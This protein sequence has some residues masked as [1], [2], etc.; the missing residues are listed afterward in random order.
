MNLKITSMTQS[1][2]ERSVRRT[3]LQRP[4]SGPSGETVRFKG[5]FPLDFLINIYIY[6]FTIS[7]FFRNPAFKFESYIHG[8]LSEDPHFPRL[9]RI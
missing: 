9:S 5:Y 1:N 4:Q 6:I 3:E 8:L 7:F 2:L